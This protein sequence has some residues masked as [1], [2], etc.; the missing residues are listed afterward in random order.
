MNLTAIILSGG[1]PAPRRP[2]LPH[3]DLVIAAD[4]GLSLAAALE[5]TVDVIVGDLDSVD[6]QDVATALEAGA[7]LETHPTDKDATDLD[8]AIE[9]AVRAGAEH[10]HVVGGGAGRLDH[11]LG[12]AL[13]V[14]SPR[15]RNHTIEW[16]T[17]HAVAYPVHDQ[18]TISGS[19]GD[20]VS[21]VPTAGHPIVSIEGTT[22]L[23]NDTPLEVGSTRGISNSL[24]EPS[25]TVRVKG[26]SVLVVHTP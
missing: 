19:S 23:L 6:P 22:W 3:A 8:L 1:G 9:A 2:S 13:L 10:I 26:G 24:T 17:E 18:R 15:W 12:V 25:A 5:L 4:S 11:L 20:L 16:H 7:T 21:V 14:A